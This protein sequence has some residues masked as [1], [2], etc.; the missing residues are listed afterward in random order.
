[1]QSAVS[2]WGERSLA[3]LEAED[4]LSVACEK[5]EA[6]EPVLLELRAA[7]QVQQ[8]QHQQS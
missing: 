5:G 8:Q 3:V 7:F 1:V 4:R 6:D 2:S